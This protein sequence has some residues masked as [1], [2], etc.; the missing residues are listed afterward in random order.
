M[1]EEMQRFLSSIPPDLRSHI[2]IE[3]ADEDDITVVWT[4]SGDVIATAAWDCGGIGYCY[5][6]GETLVP[7]KL[8]VVPGEFPGDLAVALLT[9]PARAARG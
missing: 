7:G 4:S 3:G 8:D 6:S 2:V 5:R 1:L 9:P